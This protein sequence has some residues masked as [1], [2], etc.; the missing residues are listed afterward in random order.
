MVPPN[1]RVFT[2]ASAVT[3]PASVRKVREVRPRNRRWT[4][5][6]RRKP[7]PWVRTEPREVGAEAGV[8]EA[9][10]AAADEADTAVER[11][12]VHREGTP[13]NT[14]ADRDGDRRTRGRIGEAAEAAAEAE[15][16][17]GAARPRRLRKED[18]V[19]DGRL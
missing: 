19:D 7:S 4:F 18:R 10:A 11:P 5:R 3:S 6:E 2:A 12:P 1:S 15:A 17:V 16:A 14:A 8:G 9:A 13:K